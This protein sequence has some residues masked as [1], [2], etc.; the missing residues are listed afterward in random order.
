MRLVLILAVVAVGLLVVGWAARR[1]E[2]RQKD[3]GH[4]DGYGPLVE[5]EAPPPRTG[6]AYIMGLR[7]EVVGLWKGRVLRRRRRNERP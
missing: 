7:R 2:A 4:W 3:A 6:R 1:F 5:T